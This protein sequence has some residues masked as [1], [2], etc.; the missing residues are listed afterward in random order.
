VENKF[1]QLIK[2]KASKSSD[3]KIQ[4]V[5]T[6]TNIDPINITTQ[7]GANTVEVGA[8][9]DVEVQT[10]EIPSVITNRNSAINKATP[11]P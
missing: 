11:T 10:M 9:M 5:G 2:E 7:E 3:L 4:V 1:E 6:R 8:T